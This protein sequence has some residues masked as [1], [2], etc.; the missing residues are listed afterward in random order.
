[1]ENRHYPYGVIW[2]YYHILSINL[3]YS[4]SAK[5]NHSYTNTWAFLG[6]QPFSAI[7]RIFSDILAASPEGMWGRNLGKNVVT[8]GMKCVE[9]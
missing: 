8:C 5:A 3:N 7:F 4:K 9:V 1:M 2:A 6:F